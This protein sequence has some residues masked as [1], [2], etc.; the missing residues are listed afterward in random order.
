C[1]LPAGTRKIRVKI[2]ALHIIDSI[3]DFIIERAELRLYP[4]FPPPPPEITLEPWLQDARPDAMTILWETNTNAYSNYVEW[5]KNNVNERRTKP[6]TSDLPPNDPS[7]KKYVHKAILQP[8]EPEMEYA[9]RIRF[10]D[11]ETQQYSFKTAPRKESPFTIAWISDP[12]SYT[13]VFKQIL[14]NI[15]FH[16]PDLLVCVGRIGRGAEEWHY[17]WFA[18]MREKN[19]LQTIPTIYSGDCCYAWGRIWWSYSAF[20]DN[21]EWY[22]FSYGNSRFIL[23]DSNYKNLENNMVYPKEVVCGQDEWLKRQLQSQE[24]REAAF[25]IVVCHQ[26]PFS[27][28]RRDDQ[29][30]DGNSR[31][32]EEW[33]PLFEKYGVDMVIS[34]HASPYQRGTRNGV[35]YTTIGGAG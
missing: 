13:S 5:G 16:K 17:F 6:E 26:P 21:Y 30:F 27:D 35:I 29:F 20:P 31:V 12:A 18:P 14:P 19:L 9:Y 3:N 22:A 33:V 1:Y 2:K 23:L 32:R 15:P 7:I 8:L 4:D 25:R 34:G 28:F 11:K 24:W 10:G